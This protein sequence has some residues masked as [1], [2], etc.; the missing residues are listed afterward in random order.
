[1]TDLHRYEEYLDE[2]DRKLF[3]GNGS[4]FFNFSNPFKLNLESCKTVEQLV[5]CT[6]S[7]TLM[8]LDENPPAHY[9]YITQR[10]FRLVCEHNKLNVEIDDVFNKYELTTHSSVGAIK[11]QESENE[12]TLTFVRETTS[13]YFL[14]LSKS[15]DANNDEF[16]KLVISTN[17]IGYPKFE[18]VSQVMFLRVIRLKSWIVFC[19]PQSVAWN[20]SYPNLS[21]NALKES[22]STRIAIHVPVKEHFSEIENVLT[23]LLNGTNFSIETFTPIG[24]AWIKS[25]PPVK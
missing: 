10:F 13:P 2:L 25:F 1:M 15:T 24:S 21:K 8:L 17:M 14:K 11:V 20:Y 5:E 4:V 18:Q 3:I 6:R 19:L 12:Y 7:I 22:S 9:Y 16:N 23:R